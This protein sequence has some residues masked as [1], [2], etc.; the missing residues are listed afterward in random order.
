MFP[1]VKAKATKVAA[2]VKTK[3]SAFAEGFKNRICSAAE[4]IKKASVSAFNKCKS[5]AAR[6]VTLYVSESFSYGAKLATS[7]VSVF[8]VTL[9][10][11]GPKSAAAK[12]KATVSELRAD[13]PGRGTRLAVSLSSIAAFAICIASVWFWSVNTVAV[14]VNT[15]GVCVGYVGST[16]ERDEIYEE[17][18]LILVGDTVEKCVDPIDME[19]TV[20]NRSLISDGKSLA[21]DALL[22]QST[23]I[24][25]YGL[26][27]DGELAVCASSETAIEQALDAR[28]NAYTSDDTVESKILNDISV[29]YVF[30]SGSAPV[31]DLSAAADIRNP[32]VVALSVQTVS[33]S[34]TTESI[35]FDTVTKNDSTKVVGYK[36]VQT[37]GVN[38]TAK[39]TTK[40]TSVNGVVTLSETVDKEILTEPTDKVIVCG[41]SSVGVSTVNKNLSSKGMSC[42]WPIA[43]TDRMYI[44]SYWGD[45]RNHKGFD[46]TGPEGTDIYAA[47]DGVVTFS[48]VQSGYGNVIIIE[49]KGGYQTLYAHCSRLYAKVGQTVKAG[50][51][52]AACGRTGYATGN[53]LHFEV[54]IYGT[55]VDPAPYLGIG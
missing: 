6:F 31:S 28:V 20:V 4:S 5:S 2:F 33:V 47:V 16:D 48:G 32:E 25:A 37:Q 45:N 24:P 55:P 38:G 34:E 52:I 36:R 46:I 13:N 27:V 19:Y 51:V 22:A 26:Y 43:V 49:H 30:Y 42:V 39:V 50:D 12:T 18:R 23:V 10:K 3:A 11:E 21:D 41:T 54:R 35:P 40:N 44:S 53:H 14:S 1:A 8:F 17:M 7:S 29:K 9:V 15:N